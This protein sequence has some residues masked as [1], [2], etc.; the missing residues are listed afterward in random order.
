M[1]KKE[2]VIIGSGPG[3]YV[4]AIRAAQLGQKVTIIEK[5]YIGGT[6]LNVGCIP[7]KAII[8][9]AHAFHNA[10]NSEIFGVQTGSAQIDLEKTQ[11]WKENQ[12]VKRLTGGVES[13]L[14]K[15][16]VEIIRGTASFKDN[17][18][19][20]VTKEDGSTEELEFQQAVIS[21]GTAPIE[22]AEVPFG[23]KVIDTTG[24]LGLRKAPESLVIVGGGY[25]GSQLAGA[26][27][28]L[29][30]K[31]TILEKE[32]HILHF[33]DEDMSKMVEKNYAKKGIEVIT[34]VNIKSTKETADDV[35]I[36]YEKDGK[37]ETITSSAVLV[38]AG[39][40]PYTKGLNLEEIGV[41]M[42]ENGR[43]KV[44]DSLQTSVEGI[45]AIGD[46][47]PGPA[48]AHKASY[49]G[50]IVAEVIAGQNPALEEEILPIAV[51]TEPE[52]ATVGISAAAAKKSDRNLKISKFPLAGNGRALSL[53]QT[54]GFVR[55]ITDQDND[56]ALVGAQ[57]AGVGAPDII[58]EVGFAIKN[59]MNAEDI[60]LTVHAH[61]TVAESIMDAS[62]LALGMPIHM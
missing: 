6:C 9:A 13:L 53:N 4:S 26:F 33:F 59:G 20:M 49:E 28:N 55:L 8:T 30:V 2:T 35:A 18:H 48:F 25:V 41:E 21:T 10:K 61:P 44:S 40:K 3:G 17:K 58:S 50:K 27:S 42:L 46:V 34:S 11:D 1:S 39:R 16:K 54:E 62:E 57:I 56:N 60:S 23:E 29:G 51:Y 45:Y 52:L 22:L 37:E 15:N 5:T 47:A 38:S 12:V 14:K 32:S 7:S 43:I 36:T 31:V 19:L 24:G